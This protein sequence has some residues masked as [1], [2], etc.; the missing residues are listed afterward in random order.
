MSDTLYFGMMLTFS[1][2][3]A[4]NLVG[5]AMVILVV[6]L[7][8]S[9]QRSINYLL[10]N[11]AA[12]D[13]TVAI[14]ATIQFLVEPTLSLV[15]LLTAT[16]LYKFVTGGT[17]GWVGATCSIFNLV[18]IS[19]ERYYAVIVPHRHEGKLS[20]DKLRIF[21]FVSWTLALIWASPGF[22]IKTYITEW[23]GHN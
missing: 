19:I 6:V 13:M 4:V 7:N 2:L 14:F 23:C 21:I 22:F 12:S 1:I 10:V 3:I 11:L 5:N 20:H 16:F 15:E 8:K 18:G 9:M 17:L